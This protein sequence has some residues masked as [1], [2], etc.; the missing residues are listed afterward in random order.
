MNIKF[1]IAVLLALGVCS[2]V[3]S[4][5]DTIHTHQHE[6][7]TLSTAPLK[8]VGESQMKWLWF[9]IYQAKLYTP[10]GNYLPDRWPLALELIYT[11]NISR[12]KLVETTTSEWIRQGISYQQWWLDSLNNIWPDISINDTLTL[13]VDRSGNSH[14]TY[15]DQ[16][17][18][19]VNDS[20]FTSAFTS[21]WL[22]ENTLNPTLR[23]QL[24]GLKQ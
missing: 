14:F 19:S 9:N 3:S 1:F 7:T 10:S 11:R 24:I 16:P 2:A 8:L 12:E 15:N 4:S 23:N 20:E 18:G 17:I 5:T 13:Y 21:I 6:P 22:S